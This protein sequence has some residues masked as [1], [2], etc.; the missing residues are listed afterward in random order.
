MYE[1]DFCFSAVVVGLF[2]RDAYASY[3][4]GQERDPSVPSE[5]L[6]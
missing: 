6:H 3:A 2:D 4:E 5:R 1:I